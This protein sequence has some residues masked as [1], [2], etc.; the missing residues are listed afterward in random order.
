MK[1]KLLGSTL[2]LVVAALFTWVPALAP[3]VAPVVLIGRR[4]L[5]LALYLVGLGLSWDALRGVGRRALTLG[6]VLWLIVGAASLPLAQ[7]SE[8][9]PASFAGPVAHRR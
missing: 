7:L 5:V 8:H 9:G 6:V 1:L 2:F 4:L 3:L